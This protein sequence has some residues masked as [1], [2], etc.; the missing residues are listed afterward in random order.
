MTLSEILM[1]P[2]IYERPTEFLPDR[3]LPSNPDLEKVN[4]HFVPFSRG[5]RM[6]MGVRCVFELSINDWQH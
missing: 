1:D 6:C 3:W 5:N 2:L 4:R